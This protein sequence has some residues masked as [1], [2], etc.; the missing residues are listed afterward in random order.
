[1]KFDRTGTADTSIFA[2]LFF[3]TPSASRAASGASG[4]HYWQTRRLRF[5]RDAR[6]RDEV[7]IRRDDLPLH[8][9][10]TRDTL[11]Y[12][13]DAARAKRVPGKTR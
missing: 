3:P 11:P 9:Q 10:L 1:M 7:A 5:A 13:P 2:P 8:E 12:A 6:Y 4:A